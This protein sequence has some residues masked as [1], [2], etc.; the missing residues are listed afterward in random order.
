MTRPLTVPCDLSYKGHKALGFKL[1]R[2]PLGD[3][4]K[5]K[6]FRRRGVYAHQLSEVVVSHSQP[7][8]HAEA[9]HHLLEVYNEIKRGQQ[10]DESDE[11]KQ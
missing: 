3:L 4:Q 1:L 8:P 2:L 7:E 6:F 11:L 10:G 9:L 5:S